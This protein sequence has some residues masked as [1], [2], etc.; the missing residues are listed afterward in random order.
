M[1]PSTVW[2]K[3]L[4]PRIFEIISRHCHLWFGHWDIHLCPAYWL[5][6]VIII[7]KIMIMTIFIIFIIFIIIT[8]IMTIMTTMIRLLTTFSW[9]TA[10]LIL[11]GICIGNCFFALLFKPIPESYKVGDFDDFYDED[12][13]DDEKS[14]NKNYTTASLSCSSNLFLSPTRLRI[15]VW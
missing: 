7:S 1:T 14:L 15:F 12:D 11:G 10:L 13:F 5:V 8:T 6:K 2:M 3:F 4:E 9:Q